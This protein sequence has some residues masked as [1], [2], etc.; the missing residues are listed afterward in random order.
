MCEEML[1]CALHDLELSKMTL[2]DI[3]PQAFVSR[4]ICY[5]Q[6]Q[7]L[8]KGLGDMSL[9]GRTQQQQYALRNF[10]GALKEFHT[11]SH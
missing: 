7:F 5:Q 3:D 10:R 11:L 1:K 4:N 8:I 2:R 6:H 9:D